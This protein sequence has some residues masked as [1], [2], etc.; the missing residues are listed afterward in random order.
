MVKTESGALTLVKMGETGAVNANTAA[1]Y[2]NPI[3]WIALVIVGVIAALAALVA[4]IGAVSKALS[5]AYNA[6]AIAAEKAEASARAL[7][8][9]YNEAKQSYEDMIA[10]MDE[11]KSARES[12]DSLTEGTKEYQEALEQANRAALELINNNP[13]LFKEG[14]YH[15]ENGE[16]IIND[17]AMARA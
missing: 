17:D 3:M 8:E 13:D 11:Y 9:A 1:W 15:W 5:D 14:D 16:L 7:S 2:A 10:A 6:D 12:L 4:V